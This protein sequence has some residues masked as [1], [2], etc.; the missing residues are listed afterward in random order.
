MSDPDPNNP[1]DT[2]GD[3]APASEEGGGWGIELPGGV[4]PDIS[5]L[6]PPDDWVNWGPTAD[7]IDMGVLGALEAIIGLAAWVG[8]PFAATM[9]AIACAKGMKVGDAYEVLE[10]L[11]KYAGGEDKIDM[12]DPCQIRRLA[13]IG[14]CVARRFLGISFGPDLQDFWLDGLAG[15]P[16]NLSQETFQFPPDA[17]GTP[18]T[19]AFYP[20]DTAW[21]FGRVGSQVEAAVA[22]AQAMTLW[23]GIMERLRAPAETVFPKETGVIAKEDI[24]PLRAAAAVGRGP[25]TLHTT[26]RDWIYPDEIAVTFKHSGQT[27]NT[28]NREF[29]DAELFLA[30]GMTVTSEVEVNAVAG[31]LMIDGEEIQGWTVTIVSWRLRI[32]DRIDYHANK[33]QSIPLGPV[34]LELPDQLF[35]DLQSQGCPGEPVPVDFDV[36]SDAWH[37]L[38]LSS[39]SKDVLFVAAEP[40]QKAPTS[41]FAG[42]PESFDFF[43]PATGEGVKL[44]SL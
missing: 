24:S 4:V 12:T 34:D 42:E 18:A 5:A 7:D 15:N 13:K 26:G 30:G 36:V 28:S 21:F 32:S 10:T 35:L 3:L 38:S 23:R 25:S 22:D 39:Y 8:I 16:A 6:L 1:W 40:Y 41:A 2:G 17:R 11:V 9:H 44:L 27:V 20:M 14:N 43:D 19:L 31:S 33:T 29:V 37:Q